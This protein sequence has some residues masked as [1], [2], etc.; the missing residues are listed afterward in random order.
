VIQPGSAHHNIIT[1][2]MTVM[3]V[4]ASCNNERVPK[5]HATKNMNATGRWRL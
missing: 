4:N 1:E 5:S 2:V 3:D